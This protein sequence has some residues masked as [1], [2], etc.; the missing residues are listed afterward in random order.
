VLFVPFVFRFFDYI[1]SGK[2]SVPGAEHSRWFIAKRTSSTRLYTPNLS[3]TLVRWCFTV[4]SLSEG[5]GDVFIGLAVDKGANDLKFARRQTETCYF[6]LRR[7]R[8]DFVIRTSVKCRA[9]A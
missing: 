7:A 1:T 4:Y 9:V 2:T 6:R 3:Y 8:A 5:A